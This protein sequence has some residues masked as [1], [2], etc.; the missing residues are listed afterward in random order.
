[1]T[2]KSAYAA[3]GV[4][5]EAADATK[6]RMKALVRSTFGPE[7][8]AD[9]GGFGGLFAPDW[10]A[11]QAPVLVASADGVGTKLKVAFM[12]GIHH[13]VG[14]DLVCH[15]ANDILVQGARPLFF[16]DYIGMG[17]HDPDVA[18]AVVSGVAEGCRRVGCALI[19]GE[20]ATMPDFYGPGEYD[21]AG[22]IVGVV[23]RAR[24]VD[25]SAIR[26][27]DALI[28]LGSDGL[29]TNG[30]SL[31]RRLLFEAAGMTPETRVEAWGAK[32]GEELLKPHRP[33]V[34]P[35]FR[36]L[37]QVPVHGMA[38]IT[39][40]G[41]VDNLPRILPSGSAARIEKGTWPVLPVFTTL[42]AAGDVSESE[43]YRVFNMGIGFVVAVP[44]DR[45]EETLALLK[46]QG[47]RAYRIGAV[48]DGDQGVEIV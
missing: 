40:G 3:A 28:G 2:Q 20:T 35:V 46:A 39:G 19:G 6:R 9:I 38:H 12:T 30:Y 44:P 45:A 33:Y 25:G 42:K 21:L 1:M 24:I 22:T 29:H 43:M 26:P 16:L 27:G 11:Y 23:E 13:T 36:L 14:A 4:D 41:L 18:L 5:I 15:C 32:V 8:L 7:V 17:N 31:A 47:E 10:G 48:V 34:E 37:G